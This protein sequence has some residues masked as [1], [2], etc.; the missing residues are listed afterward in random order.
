M[1]LWR[2]FLQ[3]VNEACTQWAIS[4]K[5]GSVLQLR[6]THP[7]STQG[8]IFLDSILGG[9]LCRGWGWGSPRGSTRRAVAEPSVSQEDYSTTIIG[10][11]DKSYIWIMARTPT[12]DQAPSKFEA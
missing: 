1:L 3:V 7:S 6:F 10:V 4:P 8:A 11:P 9:G 2:S 5:L 12:V